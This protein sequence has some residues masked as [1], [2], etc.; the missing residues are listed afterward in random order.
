MTKKLTYLLIALTLALSACKEEL[1]Q[2]TEV[3]IETR[4]ITLNVLL[5]DGSRSRGI[6]AG[7]ATGI[8]S[9]QMTAFYLHESDNV[10]Y[11][12]NEKFRKRPARND[13]FTSVRV[14]N[15]LWPENGA[16]NVMEFYAHYPQIA[17]FSSSG[18]YSIGTVCIASDIS[19]QFDFMTA[20]ATATIPDVKTYTDNNQIPSVSLNFAH[21]LSRI[22]LQATAGSNS[23]Y[24]FEV[25]GIRLGNPVVEGK[26][27][28]S[29]VSDA[30]SVGSWNLSDKRNAKVGYVF[31]EGDDII[32]LDDTNKPIMGNGSNAMVIPAANE[33]WVR[34]SPIPANLDQS[35]STDKMYFSVLLRAVKKNG[36]IVYPYPV[37][38][39]YSGIKVIYLAVDASNKV[40]A[41]VYKGISNEDNQTP[42]YYS[43]EK[44]EMPYQLPEGA[45]I[46]EFGWAAVPVGVDWEAGQSYRYT[47]DYSNGIGYH[48]PEDPAPGTPIEEDT[49]V[50]ISV[51][52]M[53]WEEATAEYNPTIEVPY[54]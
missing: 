17:D 2:S 41:Q 46:K 28:F 25:A 19:K 26:Y 47:L 6:E 35:Y 12:E 49:A 23:K 48:D 30:V 32:T 31:R 15:C 53:P 33:A 51:T 4:A 18:K 54:E 44:K 8:D 3:D 38:S 42:V 14:V 27:D 9:L 24:T 45:S 34:P 37:N 36:S 40:I 20:K 50:N 1:L 10:P 29:D 22:Q 39:R 21:Q 52:V 11:F 43:D 5:P 16:G 13:K 7:S